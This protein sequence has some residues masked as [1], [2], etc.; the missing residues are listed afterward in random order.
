MLIHLTMLKKKLKKNK[1]QVDYVYEV[2]DAMLEGITMS[3]QDKLRQVEPY[4]AGN[5]QKSGI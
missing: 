3:W 5:N 4:V 2:I 1:N